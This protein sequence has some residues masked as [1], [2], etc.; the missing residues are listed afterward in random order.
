MRST[1]PGDDRCSA[2]GSHTLFPE[3]TGGARRERLRSARN[4][5]RIAANIIEN[6]A[7]SS[8]VS[9]ACSSGGAGNRIAPA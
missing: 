1:Q 5:V 4:R 2:R 8:A 3:L 7:V 9:A 6:R